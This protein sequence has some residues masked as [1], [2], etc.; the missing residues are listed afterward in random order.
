IRGIRKVLF[1]P[2]TLLHPY[3]NTFLLYLK[4]LMIGNR[5]NTL[6]HIFFHSTVGISFHLFSFH[7]FTFIVFLFT[8]SNANQYFFIS[9]LNIQFQWYNSIAFFFNNVIHFINFHPIKQQFSGSSWVMI[10]SIPLL[11]WSNMHIN[12]LCFTIHNS[13]V[14]IV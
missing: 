11:I 7:I 1:Q 13:V 10:K 6:L 3:Y 9:M 12:L 5:W 4:A 14:C 8:F 2:S